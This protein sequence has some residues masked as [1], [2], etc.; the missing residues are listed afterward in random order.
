MKSFSKRHGKFKCAA[1]ARKFFN[2]CI[3]TWRTSRNCCWPP[4]LTRPK[5]KSH[6]AAP[7]RAGRW[8]NF[9]AYTAGAVE[10]QTQTQTRRLRE[11]RT[12]KKSVHENVTGMLNELVAAAAQSCRVSSPSASSSSASTHF[13]TMSCQICNRSGA[14]PS[15][16]RRED[17]EMRSLPNSANDRS[18]FSASR[19]LP[20]SF[21]L[22]VSLASRPT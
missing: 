21:S 11:S 7:E 17:L 12:K 2:L 14:Q 4:Q 22:A 9:R 19:S 13:E 10:A 1:V 6:V 16:A 3:F 15:R 18:G 8:H 5:Q 20:L